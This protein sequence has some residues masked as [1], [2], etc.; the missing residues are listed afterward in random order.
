MD[1]IQCIDGTT[2]YLSGPERRAER[3]DHFGHVEPSGLDAC[4][5]SK[6]GAALSFE[7]M[8]RLAR[9]SKEGR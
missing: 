4:R 3:C 9:W 7:D 5:C 8:A 6:C 2:Y 1:V